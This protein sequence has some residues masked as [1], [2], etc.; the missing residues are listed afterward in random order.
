MTNLRKSLRGV[1]FGALL[2]VSAVA[3][4]AAASAQALFSAPERLQEGQVSFASAQRGKPVLAGGEVVATGRGFR[5]RSISHTDVRP[6]GAVDRP[7]RR[8][9]RG[10]L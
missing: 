3:L 4:P 9:C 5:P 1:A 7:G 8:Q 10:R 2:T 6:D